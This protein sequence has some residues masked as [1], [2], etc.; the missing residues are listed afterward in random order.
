MKY[1]HYI[2]TF[3]TM[4]PLQYFMNLW[5]HSAFR[6]E[7]VVLSRVNKI[8]KICHIGNSLSSRSSKNA[9]FL[10]G[11]S[12][13]AFSGG[14]CEPLYPC[15]PLWCVQ[16][17]SDAILEWQPS[18][19]PW[20][21]SMELILVSRVKGERERACAEPKS[22]LVPGLEQCGITRHTTFHL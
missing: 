17:F 9:Y 21:R 16:E 11:S 14:F 10:Y 18:L 22:F 12:E 2:D 13:I 1:S 3:I 19:Q 4:Q 6:M 8:Y 15:V 20:L 7:T 5:P